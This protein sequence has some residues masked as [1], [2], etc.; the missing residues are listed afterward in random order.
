MLRIAVKL[1]L[2][3]DKIHFTILADACYVNDLPSRPQ[4]YHAP[5]KQDFSFPYFVRDQGLKPCLSPPLPVLISRQ[6][7]Q[8]HQIG[9]TLIFVFISGT[10]V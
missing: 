5:T 3:R 6:S 2:L 9:S 8:L 7:L 10:N 4:F 1:A